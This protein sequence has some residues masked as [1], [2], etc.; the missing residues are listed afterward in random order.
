MKK[1]I[2]LLTAIVAVACMSCKKDSE[3]AI[4]K[5][6][7]KETSVVMTEGDTVKFSVLWEPTTATAPVCTWSSSNEA[8]VTVD[9]NGNVAAV[10]VGTANI[11]AQYK[12]LSAV[13]AVE[14]KT[15]METIVFSDFSLWNVCTDDAGDIMYTSDTTYNVE[16]SIGT[17]QCKTALCYFFAWDENLGWNSDQTSLEGAGYL[18]FAVAPNP[19][20][21]E[22]QY[23]G[24]PINFGMLAFD[25]VE[26]GEVMFTAQNGKMLNAQNWF[27]YLL[28]E[29]SS[30]T[31]EDCLEGAVVQYA[32]WDNEEFYVPQGLAQN[33]YFYNSQEG[34]LIK[35]DVEWLTGTAGL[36]FNVDETGENIVAP[37]SATDYVSEVVNYEEF[38]EYEEESAPFIKKVMP[39]KAP[40]VQIMK[41]GNKSI[42]ALQHK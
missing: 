16:V 3:E 42:N 11:T 25:N 29:E 6:S 32:D 38:Y 34:L 30:L 39:A 40:L 35:F 37:K 31:E 15:W 17:V 13:C 33:G 14:V 24:Y 8:V 23:A 20:I 26:E 28:N 4:T 41:A 19:V 7:F 21:C 2:L 5:I 1:S 22:G 36:G 12:D 10:G 27:D 9:A 18:I